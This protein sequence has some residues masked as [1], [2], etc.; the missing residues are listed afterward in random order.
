MSFERAGRKKSAIAEDEETQSLIRAILT[1]SESTESDSEDGSFGSDSGAPTKKQR[2]HKRLPLF[3]GQGTTT[4]D[5]VPLFYNADSASDANLKELPLVQQVLGV[6]EGTEETE[7]PV[8]YVK[9]TGKSYI[10]CSWVSRDELVEISGGDLAIRKFLSKQRKVGMTSSQSIQSLMMLGSEEVASSWTRI[11]RVIGEN[12]EGQFFVKWC[13]LQYDQC[14]WETKEDIGSED[15]ITKF[16]ERKQ[17]WNPIK[18]MRPRMADPRLFAPILD[19]VSG[20]DGL[21]LRQYQIEGFNWL[22]YCWYNRCNSILADEMGLGKTAQIVAVLNDISVN[23]GITGPFLVLA[24]LSTLPHWQSEFERWSHMNSVIYHGSPTS[25]AIIQQYEIFVYD[26][27]HRRIPDRVGFDVLIS[28]YET[29]LSDPDLFEGIQ[30]RYL[31]L[32]EGHRLKNHAGKCYQ[33]IRKLSYEHCT[34]LTGTPVQ[35]NVEELWSLLHLLH[36]HYFADLSA[37]LSRFG[38]IDN[39][40]KVA[41]LQKLIQPFLLRRKK[42]DVDSTIAAKEETIIEVELTRIQKTYYKLLLHENAGTLISNITGGA[43]PSLLNLMM[44][45]RKVCNHPF[46]LKGVT[47]SVEEQFAEKLQMDVNDP[48]VQLRA[49]IESSG[50]MILIDKLLPK[51]KEGKHKVLI[52]SQMVKV[53]DILEEYCDLMEYPTERID[54]HVPE[55][56]RQISIDKFREDENAFVFLLCTR[57]GGVGINLTAADTVII[58]DSDWNPQNDLQAESRCHRIGQ[59][60]TVKVY[61]LVTRNTYEFEMLD[62][63]SKKLGLDHALLDGGQINPKQRPMAAKEIEKLLRSGV[64]DIANDDDTEIENF[65]SSNIDQILESRTTSFKA[66]VTST[67]SVFSKAKFDTEGDDVNAKDFWSD[68][69]S[70]LAVKQDTELGDRKCKRERKPVYREG[71]DDERWQKKKKKSSSSH[72]TPRLLC[73]RI[74]HDGFSGA[75]AEKAL[76]AY[77]ATTLEEPLDEKDE[78]LLAHILEIPNLHESTPEMEAAAAKFNPPLQEFAEKKEQLVKRVLFYFHIGQV[79]AGVQQPLAQWPASVPGCDSL[80]AYAILYGVHKNGLGSL[81]KVLEGVD[82]ETQKPL[83]D[84]QIT[85]ICAHLVNVLLPEHE[86]ILELPTKFLDPAE[87]KSVH[88]EL[89]NRTTMTNEELTSLLQTVAVL[90]FPEKTTDDGNTVV[91]WES[92]EKLSNLPCLSLEAFETEGSSLLSLAKDELSPEDQAAVL[93]RLGPYGNRVWLSR[94]RAN[95]RDLRD[96]RHFVS[97]MTD[98][99]QEQIQKLRVWNVAPEWW[100]WKMDMALLN[101]LCKYGLLYVATWIVDP[102][103]PFL[104]HLTD[105]ARSE[106]TRIAEIEKEKGKTQKPK[107]AGELA[108]LFGDKTRISRALTVIQYTEHRLD[109]VRQRSSSPSYNDDAEPYYV[110]ELSEI[111]RLPIDLSSQISV[112]ALGEFTSASSQYP[113]GYKCH[114]QYFS[115]DNPTEKSWYEATTEVNEQGEFHFRV[116][117]LEEPPMEFVS[118]TP[119][120]AWEQLIQE[121]QRVRGKMGLPKRKHTTVSGPLMFGFSHATIVNCFRLMKARQAGE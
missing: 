102:E 77:A 75:P 48:Q 94:L 26:Q 37:F 85:R 46:L 54:G 4:D 73:Y 47:E 118:H 87:W 79:L 92:I 8:Y 76:I 96:I 24:P 44:Q 28:N 22:R 115:L 53:L 5:E 119:S 99:Q 1:D 117:N 70:R 11:D 86:Q 106:Y 107:D 52:F 88:S 98:E 72:L 51:L 50:K 18:I 103:G 100:N 90:G 91:D 41:Q 56:E 10:H 6:K 110:S 21:K 74:M 9:W 89:F 67:N 116:K 58:Y 64:Y 17:K 29:M 45:L 65:C 120:G 62:R 30:W 12:A 69:M 38:V 7:N 101:A 35:N 20:P 55:T 104:E 49:L 66:D 31:V 97:N 112:L 42:S 25:R 82:Y 34:L 23:H 3:S 105:S 81:P 68:A 84:K 15:P 63:A 33:Q 40:E 114:R 57:A 32:D 16:R 108:F 113:V 19:P 109:K 121:V 13:G 61:R 43:L 71:S 83:S 14:T 59:T 95:Y 80:T 60:S 111:P 2:K 78:T 93:E 36:P 27:E 39:A